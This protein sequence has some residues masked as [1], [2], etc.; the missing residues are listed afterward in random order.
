MTH[1]VE[2]RPVCVAVLALVL[3]SLASATSAQ[4]R[5][6]V[7]VKCHVYQTARDAPLIPDKATVIRVHANWDDEDAPFDDEELAFHEARV[8]IRA[9]GQELP[10]MTHTFWR[11]DWH[12][13]SDSV[14]ASFTANH[15]GWTPKAAG[16]GRRPVAI[17]ATL[18]FDSPR[19]GETFRYDGAC[20]AVVLPRAPEPRIDYFLVKTGAWA[21]EEFDGEG[22]Q[23]QEEE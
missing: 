16:D 22:W 6:R 1:T 9:D 11:P 19:T 12:T 17:R 4:D 20:P 7:E 3:L 18:E 8:K 5:P 23:E 14:E 2:T 13:E 15:F 21:N 10:E